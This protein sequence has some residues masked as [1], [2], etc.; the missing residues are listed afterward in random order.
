MKKFL[1][2]VLAVMLGAVSLF[3]GDAEEIKALLIKD[4]ELGA[5]GDFQ[6]ALSLRTPDFVEVSSDGTVTLEQCRWLFL[7]LDGEHPEEFFLTALVHESR[8]EFKA[9]TAEQMMRIRAVTRDPDFLRE[10]KAESAK[11]LEGFK[12]D[13]ALQ[14]K[15]LK[16]VGIEVD[17]DSA[18]ARVEFD[19]KPP[20]GGIE[21]T[22]GTISLRRVDGKW[23]I[24]K[25]VFAYK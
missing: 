4:L 1:G 2:A 9:P 23:M 24:C 14:L 16:I 15:T 3:A 22:F 8:G 21:H 10:Y 17:G 11:M 20:R 25:A 7:A 18:T 12:A 13:Q 6:G 5:R 19:S